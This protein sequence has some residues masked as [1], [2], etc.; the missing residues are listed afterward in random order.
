MRPFLASKVVEMNDANRARGSME[1]ITA[2]VGVKRLARLMLALS[3]WPCLFHSFPFVGVN[4][5]VTGP[6]SQSSTFKLTLHFLYN[7]LYKVQS[8]LKSQL[9][10]LTLN[11][12]KSVLGHLY[13]VPRNYYRVKLLK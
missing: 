4:I 12:T 6:V 10:R 9:K 11:E 13:F 2:N 5:G 8:Q 7:F 3:D 1:G